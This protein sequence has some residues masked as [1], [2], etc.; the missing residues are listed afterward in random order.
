[1]QTIEKGAVAPEFDLTSTN[2]EKVSLAKLRKSA[3]VIA[4]FF[5]ISCPVCQYAFP[6]IQRIHAA[7]GNAKVKIYGVSQDPKAETERFAKE[8]GVTFPILLDEARGYP[9]SSAYGLTNVP[10]TFLVSP[11][12]DI[13]LSSVGWSKADMEEL[14][15]FVAEKNGVAV[16][17]LFR[18]DETVS[19]Y[20]PG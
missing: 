16:K 14:N 15:R 5:K 1:M 2:G 4:V 8:Y 17:P 18:P 9:V 11:E 20:R 19:D 13:K 3:P 10:T 12:G 6:Y 7:Y